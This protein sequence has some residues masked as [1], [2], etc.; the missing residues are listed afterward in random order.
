MTLLTQNAH[1]LLLA[2]GRLKRLFLTVTLEKIQL[3]LHSF[4]RNCARFGA[5]FRFNMTECKF[6]LGIGRSYFFI[7]YLYHIIAI[8]P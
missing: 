3:V 8:F 6:F 1:W 7:A 2:S 4:H 5:Y